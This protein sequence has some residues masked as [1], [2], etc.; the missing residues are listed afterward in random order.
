MRKH[1]CLLIHCFQRSYSQNIISH[2][3]LFIQLK[4]IEKMIRSLKQSGYKFVLPMEIQE[5]NGP[6]CSITFDDGYFNN[7]YFLELA[8]KYSVPII[9]FLTSYNIINQ[10]PFIWDIWE[11]KRNGKWRMSFFNYR[12]LYAE[13]NPE[14]KY[15]LQNE[16]HR[17]FTMEELK[18]FSSHPLVYL[19]PHTH[20][21]QP[22]VGKY[23]N[24][25][26]SEIEENIS[27]LKSFSSPLLNDFSLPSGLYTKLTKKVLLER[28]Q[29]IYTI[30][31]GGFSPLD[32]FINRISLVNPDVGGDLMSQIEKSFHWKS[33]SIRKITNMR[34][35][36]SLINHI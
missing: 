27:F 26:E 17:P 28:F 23:I 32:R 6:T 31:G 12:E 10:K 36:N 1:L 3:E 30:D 20:T 35:S 21:H 11:A 29:R 25:I 7:S 9:L 24:N 18:S 22:I 19:A 4:D 8:E 5:T 2:K 16:N 13:Q 14:E 15:L 34:Y 33:K